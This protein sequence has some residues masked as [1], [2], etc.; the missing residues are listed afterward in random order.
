VLQAHVV[1][2][3]P[4]AARSLGDHHLDA[5]PGEQ[6]DGRLVDAGCDNLLGTVAEERHARTSLTLSPEHLRPV[7]W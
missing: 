3:R 4:A 7:D 6:A 1:G 2:E 5:M